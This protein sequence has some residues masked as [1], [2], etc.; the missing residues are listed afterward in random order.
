M[1][2]KLLIENILSYGVDEMKEISHIFRSYDIR[3]IYKKD[4][5]KEIMK[6]KIKEI[7]C[8]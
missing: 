5:D 7:F 8:N 3:G 1:L 4:L 6:K 2:L